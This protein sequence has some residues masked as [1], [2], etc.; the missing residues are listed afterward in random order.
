MYHSPRK[1]GPRLLKGTASIGNYRI[2]KHPDRGS[3]GSTSLQDTHAILA[4]PVKEELQRLRSEA[5]EW[6][7]DKQVLHSELSSNEAEIEEYRR[8]IANLKDENIELRQE[9]NDI[10][11]DAQS[12]E[13]LQKEVE[14]L[15]DELEVVS[16]QFE[17]YKLTTG[18]D[19]EDL[20]LQLREIQSR[21]E[22]A[23]RECKSLHL[24]LADCEERVEEKSGHIEKLLNSLSQAED[25]LKMERLDKANSEKR[26]SADTDSKNALLLALGKKVYSLE[27]DIE[28]LQQQLLTERDEQSKLREKDC[29]DHSL[30]MDQLD[31]CLQKTV[32]GFQSKVD[33]IGNE[34]RE[35]RAKNESSNR[36]RD[37]LNAEM[38][39]LELKCL[40][41]SK[42]IE[43]LQNEATQNEKRSALVAAQNRLSAKEAENL[44]IDVRA[45]QQQVIS[46]TKE[47][48]A[49]RK[50]VNEAQC[51][52]SKANCDA[53]MSRVEL[54]SSRNMISSLEGRNREVEAALRAQAGVEAEA[55]AKRC[56]ELQTSIGN[57]QDLL[58]KESKQRRKLLLELQIIKGNIRVVTRVRPGSTAGT[59]L[60]LTGDS[61][62]TGQRKYSFD[63][64]FGPQTMN[65]EVYSE[66]EYL[67]TSALDGRR[68]CIFAYGQTGSG[69][70]Y[71]MSS[72]DGIIARSLQSVCSMKQDTTV[73]TAEFVEVYNESIIDLLAPQNSGQTQKI[74]IQRNVN[75]E[76]HL[77]KN[78]RVRVTSSEGA[79]ALIAEGQRRR[80]VAATKCNERSSRSHSVFILNIEQRDHDTD[81]QISRGA[82]TLVDLAGSERL[83]QS[84]VTGERLRET[85][86]INK[87][88]SCLGD[89]IHAL[90]KRPKF[91][92]PFR[93]S[94]LTFLLQDSLSGDSMAVMLLHLAPEPQH[95]A[96]TL[97]TLRFG[98]K[99]SAAK[100]KR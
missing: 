25:D 15:R 48:E 5:C 87:S 96:E 61:V 82:L 66:I 4:R 62:I 44:R 72:S 10:R 17:V 75:G 63:R 59:Q 37:R 70:T 94:K 92:V 78:T 6:A 58:I 51:A 42:A 36:H 12:Q 64:V 57:L 86:N 93:N 79:L 27:E 9:A 99:V 80:S 52:I 89:V 38:K 3:S 2:Q 23:D 1:A 73:L 31:R 39:E 20:Q 83:D 26:Y 32:A 29:V 34:L 43:E 46:L 8:T 65:N 90:I 91:H 54:E 77:A 50:T 41:Y 49:C 97:S 88:L 13:S 35:E 40:Q 76:L 53:A 16:H 21:W 98:S 84:Q 67:V 56:A 71:T 22:E 69:K 81:R 30:K 19:N 47:L 14:E 18:K 7:L 100:I 45:S 55:A 33:V 60:S 24:S 11:L 68:V 28:V 74:S 95:M 85:Q